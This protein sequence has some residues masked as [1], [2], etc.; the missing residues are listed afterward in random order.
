MKRS[1]D[2]RYHKG[3]LLTET[4]TYDGW[5][6]MDG[7]PHLYDMVQVISKAED[8]V[9]W[10]AYWP[11]LSD[12]TPD[13]WPLWWTPLIWVNQTDMATEPAIPFTTGEWDFML[14]KDYP[15]MFRGVEV[16]GVSDWH[17]SQDADMDGVDTNQVET[18]IKYMLE[19]VFN[20]WDLEKAVHKPTRTWVEWKQVSGTTYTTNHRPFAY[21]PDSEWGLYNDAEGNKVFSERVYDLTANR[22]LLRFHD[23][24]VE[25]DSNGYGYFTGLPSGHK[26]KIMYHTLP[27]FE[28][29]DLEVDSLWLYP[30]PTDSVA[31][32]LGATHTVAVQLDTSSCWFNETVD[33]NWT[34]SWFDIVDSLDETDFKVFIEE[35]HTSETNFEFNYSFYNASDILLANVTVSG[36]WESWIS[37]SKGVDVNYP[38]EN[39]TLHVKEYFRNLWLDIDLTYN[40]S[41]INGPIT[42]ENVVPVVE[43]DVVE[44]L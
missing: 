33:H 42:T 44:V 41:T 15:P 38:T 11:T 6:L 13:G 39:G 30:D 18:E 24:D 3:E 35:T 28:L 43:L 25:V 21:W 31:D 26:L 23:Y 20:P 34:R 9:L 7:V 4:W 14:G 29:S 16:V 40:T 17:H 32:W 22:L 8:N 1:P 27:D 2:G 37:H 12:Y 5:T 10:K 19:E 36:N